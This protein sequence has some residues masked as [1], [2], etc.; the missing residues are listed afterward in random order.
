MGDLRRIQ[1][2]L[3]ISPRPGA[4][5]FQVHGEFVV[6]A[7]TPGL[8]AR[9]LQRRLDQLYSAAIRRFAAVPDRA[10]IAC[11]WAASL[12][13]GDVPGPYWALLT[14]PTVDERL[15]MRAFG[16]VHMLSHL[17]GAANHA[18]LRRLMLLESER[19]A[20]AD[21]LAQAKR[22]LAEQE[23]D[24]HR[25]VR[26]HAAEVQ[27]LSRRADATA[28]VCRQL[29]AAEARIIE[30]ERGEAVAR[31]GQELAVR[32]EALARADR[33]LGTQRAE[34]ALLVAEM[35]R[36]RQQLDHRDAAAAALTRECRAI[37]ALLAAQ[38]TSDGTPCGNAGGDSNGG[39]GAP[40]L[41]GRRIVY[42]GGLT[43]LVPHLRS[44]VE[45][46]GGVFHHHDGGIEDQ[47]CRLE[48][49][50]EPGAAVFCP[51]DCV[52]H[53]ASQRAKRACRQRAAAFVPLRTASLSAFAA[54]LSRLDP[55]PPAAP[56]RYRPAG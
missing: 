27:G 39:G 9:A 42:V 30:L 45:R 18:D 6:A 11:L 35:A 44:L 31:L 33:E 19:D 25:L 15:R 54:G 53:D 55:G 22:R 46:A 21:R 28:A 36:L 13:A 51:V 34:I 29:A 47:A 38:L 32:T 40:A 37:E 14:H 5:D 20:L 26:E 12:A 3:R 56:G 10:D 17:V 16:E 50:L 24:L 23:R 48:A 1:R 49:L 2:R 43:G 7:A 4:S 41:G 8:V 52:S